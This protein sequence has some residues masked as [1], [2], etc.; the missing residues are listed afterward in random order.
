MS[1]TLSLLNTRKTRTGCAR[2]VIFLFS[3]VVAPNSRMELITTSILLK[4][5]CQL[6]SGEAA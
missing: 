1:L 4:R 5:L 3:L 6:L 2:L